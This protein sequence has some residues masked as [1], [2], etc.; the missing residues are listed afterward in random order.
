MILPII[1]VE[2]ENSVSQNCRLGSAME[3]CEA[4]CSVQAAAE[5]TLKVKTAE[6]TAA[7]E[8]A[9]RQREQVEQQN[10]LLHD[11][12]EK[13]SQSL[14]SGAGGELPLAPLVPVEN[15]P[16]SAPSTLVLGSSRL[17]SA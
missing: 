3:R 17:S 2:S 6:L 5:N 12:L 8:A 9:A 1:S 11:Q 15:G 16:L 10:K 14:P 4:G 7:A 13:L